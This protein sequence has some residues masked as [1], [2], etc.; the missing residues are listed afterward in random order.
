VIAA[1]LFWW[2]LLAL[3]F[4]V[5]FVVVLISGVGRVLRLVTVEDRELPDWPMISIIVPA[6]NEE[7]NIRE[8]LQSLLSLDYPNYEIIVVNDRSSDRTGEILAEIAR[9]QQR[10]RVENIHELPAGWLGKNH[11]L[12]WAAKSA[13]GEYIL[14][15]DADVIFAPRALRL[16]ILYARQHNLDH[17]TSVMEVEVPGWLMQSYALT[18]GMF[19]LAY[20]R[21]WQ[22]SRPNNRKYVGIGAFNLVRAPVYRAI[23]GH[24]PIAMRPDDDVMLGKLIKMNGYRQDFVDGTQLMR[25]PWYGSLGEMI[26][27]LEKNQFSGVEYSVPVVVGSSFLA[28]AGF[29]APFIMVFLST[30]A[31]QW[32]FGIAALL[33]WA[34]T[35]SCAWS[36]KQS[37]IAALAFPISVLLFVYIQWRT[38][39][40]V[41]A[42]GGLQWRDT[43][44]S[45]AELKANKVVWPE[46]ERSS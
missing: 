18:F 25:V 19:F 10:L 42:R 29:V 15:T 1:I 11:A 21:P 35:I 44:Y 6:R 31:A 37:L 34:I 33:L 22:A 28:L 16:A 46:K 20:F 8:A 3:L 9:D 13:V 30:G 14:F 41:L 38:M 32:M 12:D 39:L 45:L 24:A 27:G 36:M 23:C 26:R 40:V 4:V 17:L 43:F 7:R 2:A 5:Y